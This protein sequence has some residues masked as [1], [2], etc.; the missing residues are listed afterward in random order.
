[1]WVRQPVPKKVASQLI[2]AYARSLKEGDHIYAVRDHM[3][4]PDD[5]AHLLVPGPST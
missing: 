3:R 1:M 5:A 4:L 2:E